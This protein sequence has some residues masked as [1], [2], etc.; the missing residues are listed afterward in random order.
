[1][2]G[3]TSKK[4]IE[5]CELYNMN[6]NCIIDFTKRYNK[7][8][9]KLYCGKCDPDFAYQDQYKLNPNDLTPLIVIDDYLNDEEENI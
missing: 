4:Q 8:V 5:A 7:N 3:I 2:C 6:H 1:M 9:V